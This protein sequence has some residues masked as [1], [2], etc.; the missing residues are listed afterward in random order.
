MQDE[1]L[2]GSTSI[3]RVRSGWSAEGS[4][5]GYLWLSKSRKN[6]SIRTSTL[7]GCTM[8]AS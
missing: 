4:M 3:R 2:G 8:A 5:T 1:R 7:E 6:R